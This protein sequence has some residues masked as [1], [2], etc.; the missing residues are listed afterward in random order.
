MANILSWP[1]VYISVQDAKDSNPVLALLTDDEVQA[2]IYQAQVTIDIYIKRTRSGIRED[3]QEF[4]FPI[5]SKNIDNVESALIPREIQLSTLYIAQHIHTIGYDL[6][7]S[8]G[9]VKKETS[10]PRS[11]EFA[12]QNKETVGLPIPNVALQMLKKW[13]NRFYR[14]SI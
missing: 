4:V 2:L 6:Q 13:K 5:I 8:N 11:I 9:I 12:E 1:A 7:L 14:A 10:W 3:D